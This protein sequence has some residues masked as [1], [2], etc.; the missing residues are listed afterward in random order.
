VTER[1]TRLLGR[2]LHGTTR[3]LPRERRYWAEAL[4]AE[5]GQVPAGWPRLGWLAGG[6]LLVAKEAGMARK[7]G[8][9]IGAA[10][11]AGVAAWVVWLSWRTA[12]GADPERVTDRIRVLVGAVALIALPWVAR[13]RGLF[14]PVGGSVAARLVRVAACA[15]ICCMGLALV[16][17]DRH[18][19]INGVIGSGSVNWL[20]EAAGLAALSTGAAVLL[21]IVMARRPKTQH[22][23]LWG[24]VLGTA[25][26]ALA[27]VPFQAIV[28]G[29]AAL[30]FAATSRRSP[31][32]PAT[33]AIGVIAGLP[34]AVIYFAVTFASGNLY[35][36][37][38][39]VGLVVLLVAGAAG[40]VAA[41]RVTGI[42]N[43]DELRSARVTQGVLAGATAGAMAGLLPTAVFLIMGGMMI[44][45]P[46]IGIAGAAIGAAFAADRRNRREALPGASGNGS[47][48]SLVGD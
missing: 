36:G 47:E 6:M 38:L 26:L 16:R 19:G 10:A 18:A 39:A 48:A 30:I 43:P 12:P 34:P 44:L 14:G 45:G 8:Y 20:R 17:G 3:L 33:L 32:A 35:S 1:L 46:P 25:A 15:A 40:A 9:W 27:L 4:H 7:I 24:V 41:T 31:L 23:R 29:Y 13:Q 11:V 5:A 37:M 22:P 21:I 2:I 42:D 28:V